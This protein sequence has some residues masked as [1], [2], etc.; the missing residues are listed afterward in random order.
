MRFRLQQA[1]NRLAIEMKVK[2]GTQRML[3]AICERPDNPEK[4]L[5][6][7]ELETKI[8]ECKSKIFLLEISRKRYESVCVS[9]DMIKQVDSV[10][11]LDKLVGA[12]KDKENERLLS[13]KL[14]IKFFSAMGLPGKKSTKTSVY[15]TVSVDNHQTRKTKASTG[16]WNEDLSIN[17]IQADEI[18]ICVYESGDS[19][20]NLLGLVWFKMRDLWD[21]LNYRPGQSDTKGEDYAIEGK[22]R[23]SLPSTNYAGGE[24]VQFWL[25]L[26]P[27][28]RICVA[29]KFVR[30]KHRTPAN[31]NILSR[32]K[33]V[34]KIVLRCGHK[35]AAFSTYQ[36]MKC[37]TC[38]EFL[39]GGS[40]YRC[41]ACSYVSH[42]RCI[43]EII[44]KCTSKTENEPEDPELSKIKHH[45]PH[46]F[47]KS[48][49]AGVGWCAHCGMMS[50][51]LKSFQKCTECG[52][53]AH[54]NCFSS[55]PNFCGLPQ[56][57]LET[58]RNL[59]GGAKDKKDISATGRISS[60]R[61][62]EGGKFG[63]FTANEA[64]DYAAT[65]G[66]RE[67]SDDNIPLGF[68][69][70]PAHLPKKQA[71]SIPSQVTMTS[72]E[73]LKPKKSNK[74]FRGGYSGVSL[75]DF[76]L[77]AVLGRGNFGKVMLA[78][79]KFTNM[80]YAIKILKKEFILEHD[81]VER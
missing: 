66:Y 15:A 61:Q 76:H 80:H 63:E 20:S 62:K 47:V 42:I 19:N 71:S 78:K 6:M 17:I 41:Q 60:N 48:S 75:D 27:S 81:E 13:G 23:P 72:N 24:M 12:K 74:N 70:N 67:D 38:S 33:A 51:S 52:I 64:E 34:Q 1:R 22:R 35:L 44:A 16:T 30:E 40:G 79:E 57:M 31:S 50:M 25:D 55:I 18:E 59:E 2:E 3:D 69:N 21:E 7:K 43:P 46:R 68:S 14:K 45:I 4:L 73:N 53:L 26:V 39:S 10:I 37:A 77:V 58:L 56:G 65:S 49:G 9:S 32:Q 29:I 28:G 54:Q 5:K 8:K 11:E 36:V